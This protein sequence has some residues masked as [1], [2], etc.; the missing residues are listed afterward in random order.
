MA[1]VG[2]EPRERPAV[3]GPGNQAAVQV[4]HRPVLRRS[5]I[6]AHQGGV[7]RQRMHRRQIV[8]EAKP[9]GRASIG[10]NERPQVG[11]VAGSLI[12]VT[13]QLGGIGQ[14]RMHLLVELLGDKLVQHAAVFLAWC[15]WRW[16]IPFPALE[17]EK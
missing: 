5:H 7:H 8:L 6:S 3:H 1:A 2:R 16:A 10:H 15:R 13:P 4:D 14:V 12:H 11:R 17:A 9:H